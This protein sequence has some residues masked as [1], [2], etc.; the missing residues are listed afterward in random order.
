[1][2]TGFLN[3]ILSCIF[4][5]KHLPVRCW[6]QGGGIKGTSQ[7]ILSQQGM[8]QIMTGK[9][10]MAQLGPTRYLVELKCKKHR[11]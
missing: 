11:T 5:E 1:M 2:R 4:K 6:G 8:A 9:P 10:D 7:N 3:V